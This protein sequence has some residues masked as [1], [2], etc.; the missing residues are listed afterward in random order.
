MVTRRL[1]PALPGRATARTIDPPSD[2]VGATVKLVV[3][4]LDLLTQ[5]KVECA[6]HVLP[7]VTHYEVYKEAC[8]AATQLELDRFKK[9]FHL[10]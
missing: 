4:C 5:C 6:Y 3:L 7:G 1:S 10:P 9:H 2:V 8:A